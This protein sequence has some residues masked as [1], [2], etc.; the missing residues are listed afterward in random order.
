MSRT[1]NG[2][3]PTDVPT[4]V[5][6][7]TNI[8]MFLE[9]IRELIGFCYDAGNRQVNPDWIAKVRSFLQPF[10]S[11]EL[12]ET[13]IDY[14]FIPDSSGKVECIWDKI[15]QRDEKYISQNANFLFRNLPVSE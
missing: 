10:S 14:S 6:F 13:F 4:L 2:R 9:L 15:H 11:E 1:I 7:R 5:R 8:D 3:T 12:I